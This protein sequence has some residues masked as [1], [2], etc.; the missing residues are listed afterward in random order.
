[1]WNASRLIA[2]GMLLGIALAGCQSNVSNSGTE[3]ASDKG[4]VQASPESGI[5]AKV[6]S[7]LGQ[8]SPEDRKLAESQKFCAVLDVNGQTV[9]VCCKGCRGKA[10]KNPEQTLAKVAELKTQ[11]AV[12]HP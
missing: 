3:A 6:A 9:F 10:Q 7:M 12:S 1:M 8:L 11:N 4:P 2:W 5:E